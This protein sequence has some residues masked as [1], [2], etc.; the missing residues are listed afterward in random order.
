MTMHDCFTVMKMQA[1]Q[2]ANDYHNVCIS[3]TD[4][5]WLNLPPARY[6]DQK[7]QELYSSHFWSY[8]NDLREVME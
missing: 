6:T 1:L 2:D 4:N 7:N 3:Q 5:S 8:L